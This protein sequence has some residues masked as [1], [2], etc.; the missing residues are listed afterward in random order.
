ME[1]LFTDCT[2]TCLDSYD[3]EPKLL[4]QW[5]QVMEKFPVAATALS[6]PVYEKLR[7]FF[8]VPASRRRYILQIDCPADKVAYPGFDGYLLSDRRFL[9]NREAE[10]FCCMD[11]ED[12]L[13]F[14]QLRGFSARTGISA[15]PLF[16]ALLEKYGRK[17]EIAPLNAHYCAT[18]LAVQ[19]LQQGG[20]RIAA[21]LAGIGGYACMEEVLLTWYLKSG[22]DFSFGRVALPQ[23]KR[24]LE[25]MIGHPLNRKKAVLGAD[26]FAVESGIHVD[27]LRK[28][29]E[30]YEP[31]PPEWVG[32]K[33]NIVL[34]KYSGR[35]AVRAKAQALGMKL[36]NEQVETVIRC[37]QTVCAEGTGRLT[38]RE[39]YRLIHD[40]KTVS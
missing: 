38:E 30:L 26:I 40:Q 16:A 29:P 31:Y 17:V 22:G 21:S 35:S 8:A 11:S 37:L 27:G 32:L 4:F 9:T 18:A 2:L 13:L 34:G 12:Q 20:E 24:L 25:Q 28:A 33:R 23:A 5:L 6:I 10:R 1:G 19:W 7:S 15:R 39:F 36:E 14:Y 3:V